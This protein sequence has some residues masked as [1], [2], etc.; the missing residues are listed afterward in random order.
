MRYKITPGILSGLI[1]AVVVGFVGMALKAMGVSDRIY[2]D[3]AKTIILSEPKPGLAAL[4]V[5]WLAHL[6]IGSVLG[7]VVCF[8]IS[9][10]SSRFWILKSWGI[11]ILSWFV[12]LAMGTITRLPLF[13]DIPA[14]AALTLFVGAA[15]WG[16]TNIYALKKITDDFQSITHSGQEGSKRVISY[17]TFPAPAKKAEPVK[18]IVKKEKIRLIRPK[19]LK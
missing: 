8:F 13:G 17:G 12:L 2:I 5:G 10:T 11:G 16:L 1:G 14:K 9:M 4:I 18:K 7:A 6:T 15:L 19:K 3:L